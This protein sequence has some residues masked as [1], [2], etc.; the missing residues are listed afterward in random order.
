MT[1]MKSENGKIPA[2]VSDPN[3]FDD[4]PLCSASELAALTP[5]QYALIELAN[6]DVRKI[7]S[8]DLAG[9]WISRA[10]IT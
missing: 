1:M 4:I 9:I 2:A 10:Q 6:G 5:E 3:P 8:G 7:R